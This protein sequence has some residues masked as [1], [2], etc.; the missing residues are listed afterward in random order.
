MP[1]TLPLALFKSELY[2]PESSVPG[3]GCIYLLSP[4]DTF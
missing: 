2:E 4:R 3:D 1:K